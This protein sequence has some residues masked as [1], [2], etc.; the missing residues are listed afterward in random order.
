MIPNP[1]S[2]PSGQTPEEK[3]F[4]YPGLT[5]LAIGSVNP[6][7][8]NPLILVDGVSCTPTSSNPNDVESVTVLK[9]A[10]SPRYFT[11][12][13][14][15]MALILILKIGKGRPVELFGLLPTPY[16]ETDTGW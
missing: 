7:V 3:L 9:Y 14:P 5:T 4:Q 8:Q 1:P 13:G 2:P 15:L 6:T 16:P 11:A 10:A 12:A